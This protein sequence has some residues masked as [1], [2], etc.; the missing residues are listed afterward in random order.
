MGKAEDLHK[1]MLAYNWDDGLSRPMR[2][3]ADPA[4]DRGTALLVFWCLMPTWYQAFASVEEVPG[5]ARES[6]S[7]VQRLLRDYPESWP[8][9]RIPF[10]PRDS[11]RGDLTRGKPDGSPRWEIPAVFFA[12][13]S[14]GEEPPDVQLSRAVDRRDPVGCRAAVARGADPNAKLVRAAATDVDVLAALLEAGA[15]PDTGSREFGPALVQA[16][17]TGRADCVRALIAAGAKVDIVFKGNTPLGEALGDGHFELVALLRDA[18]ANPKKASLPGAVGG[19]VEAVRYLLDAGVSVDKPT[20]GVTALYRAADRGQ[21]EVVRV[22]LEA[23]AD[24]TIGRKK[25][26]RLPREKAQ[27]GAS[28]Y[29]DEPERLAG[30]QAVLAM[31]SS[32]PG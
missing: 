23:G 4:C 19:G 1:Q 30:Y 14:D 13:S 21:A 27:E 10:D 6:W 22:L 32:G 11:A 31:L 2:A 12:P 18:G 20:D 15:D 29:C 25:D 16:V 26:G 9:S 24:P 5:H 7:M 28:R 3:L 17:R 8:N